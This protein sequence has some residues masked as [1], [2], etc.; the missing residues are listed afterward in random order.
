M[1]VGGM[2]NKKS[3]LDDVE[4]YAPGLPCHQHKLPPYP[5]KVIGATG[6]FAKSG[7][8]IVC[9]GSVQKY[10]NIRSKSQANLECTSLQGIPDWCLGPKTKECYSYK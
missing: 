8:A 7:R 10:V 1:L 4:L 9:G 2:G 3:Y 6:N 5:M